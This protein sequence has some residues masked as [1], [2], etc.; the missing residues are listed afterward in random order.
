MGMVFLGREQLAPFLP[1]AVGS[2]RARCQC[3][4]GRT[5]AAKRFAICIAIDV[6]VCLRACLS[7]RLRI[8]KT[9]PSN[10][11]YLQLLVAVARFSS[12]DCNY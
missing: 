11:V 6:T 5:P 7:V 2:G 9:Y 12:D 4:P 1:A 8:S 3:D 10:F